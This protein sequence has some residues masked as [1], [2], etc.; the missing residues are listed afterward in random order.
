[1]RIEQSDIDCLIELSVWLKSL[2]DLPVGDN[3]KV[4]VVEWHERVRKVYI[5]LMQASDKG[6]LGLERLTK[7]GIS[8]DSAAAK[9]IRALCPK[10][11]QN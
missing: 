5:L 1:M 9:A 4:P 2:A 11:G 7:E 10:T 6:Q 3:M 8:D